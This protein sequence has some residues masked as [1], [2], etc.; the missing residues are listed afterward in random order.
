[1]NDKDRRKGGAFDEEVR[2]GSAKTS[3]R[4]VQILHSLEQMTAFL[5]LPL[6]N[7]GLYTSPS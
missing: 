3:R 7:T 1:M 5:L 2:H 4:R 6:K